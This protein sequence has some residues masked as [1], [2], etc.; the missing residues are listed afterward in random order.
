MSNIFHHDP[1]PTFTDIYN[2]M[3]DLELQSLA[4]DLASLLPDAQTALLAEM[5]A[6]GLD[7]LPPVEREEGSAFR[8]LTTVRRYRDLSEALVARGAVESAGIFCFLTDENLVRLDWQISNSIGGI[9]LQVAANDVEAA[10]AILAQPAP[11]SIAMR[12]QPD[13]RQPRCPRCTSTDIAWERQGRKV[14][15]AALYLFSLPVPRGSEPWHCN[16]C[17]LKWQQDD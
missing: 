14:A 12:D 17:D 2:P 6:R 5:K 13:F 11:D 8:D 3:S 16:S 7:L 1:E 9:R 10:E 15:L 4:S